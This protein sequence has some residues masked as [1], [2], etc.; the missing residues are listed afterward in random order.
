[1][2][3]R[4]GRTGQRKYLLE[5]E[6][7]GGARCLTRHGP[8]EGGPLHN[9][10]TAALARPPPAHATR[11]DHRLETTAGPRP[12][13]RSARSPPAWGSPTGPFLPAAGLRALDLTRVIAGPAAIR[14][15]ALLGAD[16]L[17]LDSPRLP[18]IGWQHLDT[19]MGKRSALVDLDTDP[20]RLERLLDGADV[21]ITGY[22]PVLWTAGGS[23]PSSSP[24]ANRDW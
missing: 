10:Q 7:P 18:E 20:R 4:G 15:L 19:G 14:T 21:V 23:A 6:P 13:R 2:R 12:S 22:A 1:M 16:V 17:R 9:N 24:T 8:P 11:A 5:L 3:R